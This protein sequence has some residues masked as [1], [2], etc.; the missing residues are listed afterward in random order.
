MS[1][2]LAASKIIVQEEDPGVRGIAGAPTTVCGAV[3]ITERGPVGKATRCSSLPDYQNTFG[4][5]LP[6]SDLSQAALGFFTNSGGNGELWVVRTVHYDDPSDPTTAKATSAL[7]WLSAVVHQ[8]ASV[9]AGNAAPYALNDGDELA[10]SL[11]SGPDL[12]VTFHGS[13]AWLAAGGP[14]PFALADGQTL[15]IKVDGAATPQIVTFSAHAF[16]NIAAATAQE[17]AHGRWTATQGR[18]RGPLE[19][20]AALLE[21][22]AR[23]REPHRGLRRQRARRFSLSPGPRHRRRQCREPRRGRHRRHRPARGDARRP[24]DGHHRRG[25]H[26][27]RDRS[28]R[29]LAGAPRDVS[30]VRLRPERPSPERRHDPQGRACGC[31]RPRRLRQ[32]PADARASGPARRRSPHARGW[33]RARHVPQ[34]L[35]RSDL[36]P[37][38]RDARQRSQHGS[39]LV[40]VTDQHIAPGGTLALQT[41]PLAGGDD[42]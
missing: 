38:H 27:P 8:A 2:D 40:Q 13:P 41:A 6:T 35:A 34:R 32:P 5:I 15:E 33:G 16:A 39:A 9:V 14:G 24:H 7:G 21:R 18:H 30:G 11:G 26:A 25:A 17:V 36:A 37:L 28:E 31:R 42:G 12:V 1:N 3:G 22:H 20:R 10:V 4:R 29:H 23:N 19:W